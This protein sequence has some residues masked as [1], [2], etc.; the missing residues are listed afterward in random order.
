MTVG[1]SVV[2]FYI[3]ISC[4]YMEINTHVY[5]HKFMQMTYIPLLFY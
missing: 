5:A 1:S 4:N 2:L 3:I